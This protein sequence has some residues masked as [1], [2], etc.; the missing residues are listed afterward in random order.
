[1]ADDLSRFLSDRPIRARR[2]TVVQWARK[3]ARRHPSV[4]GAA[5]VLCVLTAAFSLTSREMIRSEQTKTQAA[6]EAEQQ[7]AREAEDRFLLARESVDEMVRVYQEELAD[8]PQFAGLRRRLLEEALV[9]YQKLIDQRGDDPTAQKE[10][11]DTRERI[12]K[13]LGDLALL[14]G[15]G[16]LLLLLGE[17]SV[18]DDLGLTG[19]EREQVADLVRRLR[20]RWFESFRGFKQL[21]VEERRQRFVEVARANGEAAAAVLT[22]KQ[23]GR[24]KQIALQTL[25]PFAFGDADVVATLK[26]TGPQKE[27]IRAIEAE[28]GWGGPDRGPGGPGLGGPDGWPGGPGPGEPPGFRGPGGFGGPGQG[29]RRDRPSPR[30]PDRGPGSPGMDHEQMR[31]T[32]T[33][34]ILGLLTAEQVQSWR[35]LTGEPFKGTV[36]P[37][38]PPLGHP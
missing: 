38:P 10:L 33:E 24:L 6:Y 7:R 13:I 27:R 21:T 26:L 28:V 19:K 29:P 31:R 8:M 3:W 2:T 18:L 36:R 15:D 14:Q 35:D 32:A 20:E 37:C 5:I 11:T 25:G 16:Q 1:M 17:S 34:K 23:L 22:P 30:N 12:Q 9:F 4:V